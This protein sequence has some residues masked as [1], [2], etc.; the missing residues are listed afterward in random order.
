MKKEGEGFFRTAIGLAVLL[1]AAA[2]FWQ[3]QRPVN[4]ALPEPTSGE[5][6]GASSISAFFGPPSAQA[7]ARLQ[8]GADEELVAAIDLAETRVEAAL[9]DLNLWTVRDALIEAHRRGVQ[10][11]VVME[12]DQAH[13]SEVIDLVEAG[14]PVNYDDRPPLMHHK[15]IVIDGRWVWTGSMNWTLN[16]VYRNDNNV[17]V[18]DS[19][20]M[21]ANFSTEFAEM[22]EADRFGE[23][24][25]ADTPYPFLVIGEAGVET[26]FAPEDGVLARILRSLDRAERSI[27]VL[28]FVFTSDPIAEALLAAERRGVRVRGVFEAKRVGDLGSDVNRL[29][30][31]GLSMRLDTNPNT[32]HH[33][34]ILID[35]R[36]VI[37]GSYNFT[38]SA[39]E[40]NDENLLLIDSEELFGLYQHEFERLYQA[41]LP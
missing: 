10:V 30:E 3:S 5:I 24:S 18:I 35:G 19:P 32:M 13:R 39:E 22:F 31:A 25:L 4:E 20:D 8:G 33:K 6:E 12:A 26:A 14:I 15:F 16:G 21:A 17:V 38:R 28:A 2:L 29:R 27:D 1:A 23:L 40:R 37:T 7:A 11:R 34:V 9:Y 36:L 41:A